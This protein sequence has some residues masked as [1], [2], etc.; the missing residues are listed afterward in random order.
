MFAGK[1]GTFWFRSVIDQ[2]WNLNINVKS[3]LFTAG[4]PEEA[5]LELEEMTKRY[6]EPPADLEYGGMKD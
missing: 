1:P 6:G 4:I 3:L 2:R 5:K